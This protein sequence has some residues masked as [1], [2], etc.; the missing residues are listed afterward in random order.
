M[1]TPARYQK[2]PNA[3]APL[4]FAIASGLGVAGGMSGTGNEAMDIAILLAVLAGV[5]FST[6]YSLRTWRKLNDQD[7]KMANTP[8]LLVSALALGINGLVCFMLATMMILFLGVLLTGKGV[9]G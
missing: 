5:V 8:R 7:F 4:A 2:P 1:P 3:I 9:V 6:R